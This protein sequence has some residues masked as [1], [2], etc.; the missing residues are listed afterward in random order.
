[1]SKS[2]AQAKGKYARNSPTLPT[3]TCCT[4]KAQISRGPSESSTAGSQLSSEGETQRAEHDDESTRRAAG[5]AR[6][7]ARERKEA[8]PCTT[9][10]VHTSTDMVRNTAHVAVLARLGIAGTPPRTRP[11]QHSIISH[12][13]TNPPRS[14][15]PQSSPRTSNPTAKS[16]SCA[17]GTW[18]KRDAKTCR[19][20]WAL[21]PLPSPSCAVAWSK[22]RAGERVGLAERKRLRAALAIARG[23]GR[24]ALAGATAGAVAERLHRSA[25]LAVAR[26]AGDTAL[27]GASAAAYKSHQK[28]E[29]HKGVTGRKSASESGVGSAT[30]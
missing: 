14:S 16:S 20:V 7:Y 9:E 15:L 23:A 27:S 29:R 4:Y 25:A 24:T 13:P 11:W 6:R 3:R 1:M 30:L 28:R 10:P 5:G 26:G 22:L 21:A 12:H 8:K 2:R 17:Y 19:A 18:R